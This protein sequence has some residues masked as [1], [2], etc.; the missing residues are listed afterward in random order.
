MLILDYT[1][2]STNQIDGTCSP[3]DRVL[4]I[5]IFQHSV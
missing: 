3:I 2:L 4:Y 1:E 5:P